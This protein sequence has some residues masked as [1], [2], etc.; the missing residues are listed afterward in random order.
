IRPLSLTHMRRAERA[1]VELLCDL[2]YQNARLGLEYAKPFR[3]VQSALQAL[4]IGVANGPGPAQARARAMHGFVLQVLGAKTRGERDRRDASA[5]AGG[6]GHSGT[7]AFCA[8]LLW[9]AAGF[10]GD[11]DRALALLRDCLETYEPWFELNE[12]CNSVAAAEFME[13]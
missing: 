8:R 11:F 6:A 2:H 10:S 4:E 1:E 9:Y 7:S 12:F 3:L 5:V 13:S